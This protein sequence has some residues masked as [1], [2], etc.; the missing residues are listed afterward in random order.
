[1]R[2]LLWILRI[3]IHSS[4]MEL[5]CAS[6]TLGQLGYFCK[7][8]WLQI[9]IP[10]QVIFPFEI[11]PTQ[12]NIESAQWI[13]MASV[14]TVLNMHPINS[15]WFG[16][17]PVAIFF[18]SHY[19]FNHNMPLYCLVLDQYLSL[20]TSTI[21]HNLQLP[22][23]TLIRINP[24]LSLV[25]LNLLQGRHNYIWI[26]NHISIWTWSRSLKFFLAADKDGS[27]LY[28][29]LNKSR[30]SWATRNCIRAIRLSVSSYSKD[31]LKI[32][33]LLLYFTYF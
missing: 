6:L 4:W 32:T 1:M 29:G 30:L 24:C 23:S 13:L 19:T 33:D 20:V 31:N 17:K 22:H 26:S 18:T 16:D 15:N 21:K 9:T 25:T 14:A 12:N 7:C 3:H 27:I 8:K 10:I 28:T 11:G 2:C 5:I